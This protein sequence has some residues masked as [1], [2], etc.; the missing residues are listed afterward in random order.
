M[1]PIDDIEEQEKNEETT[2]LNY[3]TPA[4]KKKWCNEGDKIVMEYSRNDFGLDVSGYYF[5]NGRIKVKE[6]GSVERG[7]KNKVDYLLLCKGNYPLALVEAKGYDHDINDG[8][9]Q[10]LKYARLLDVPFAYTSN[11]KL[12]HEEDIKMGTNREFALEDFPTSDEL[13]NRYVKNENLTQEQQKIILSP[14]YTLGNRKQDTTNELQ[15]I[16]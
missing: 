2:K 7:K 4:L 5:T 6:D 3:V 15:L 1:K 8:V 12:F 14:Y 9:S 11:G 10:A 13:W 16:G